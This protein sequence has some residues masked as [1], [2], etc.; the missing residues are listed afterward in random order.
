MSTFDRQLGVLLHPTS[1]A[2][3]E[4]IG[5]LGA[6]ARGALQ[7]M[8][9]A[10]V[11]A[12]QVLPLCEG[13]L[14]NSPY[15]SSTSALGNPWLIDLNDLARDQLIDPD[16][17]P[18]VP[19]GGAIDYASLMTWKRPLLEHAARRLLAHSEYPLHGVFDAWRARRPWVVDAALFRALQQ[20]TSSGAWWDWPAPLR[21]REPAA[22][23]EAR[24]VHAEAIEVEIALAFLFDHQ[25]R[26]LAAQADDFG[27]RLIGDVPI[28]VSPNSVEVW[29][30]R[31]LFELGPDGR[32][33]RVAGVPP[34]AFSATGQHW[35]NPLYDWEAMAADGYAW[36]IRRLKRA[37]ERTPTLR[38]D[39]FRGFVSYYAIDAEAAD[40][41]QGTWERG[42]G[43]ALFDALTEAL[44]PQS[45]I[46]EDLGDID[47]TVHDFRRSIGCLAT[48]VLQFGLAVD[49]DDDLHQPEQVPEDAVVYTGTH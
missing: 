3:F 40:A 15:S 36:W 14:G 27:V 33:L 41:T 28:Y 10:G 23:D 9:M 21:D 29:A 38:L 30:H 44:G 19:T 45:F 1:L 5:T 42:P 24:G 47:E 35:G 4:P 49:R 12:W 18:S 8:G 34:D 13:G 6:G 37:L 32:P 22:L 20:A 11:T 16:F 2:S 43:L 48:R 31:E 26:T 25:W 39:H 46:A 17:V 7:W